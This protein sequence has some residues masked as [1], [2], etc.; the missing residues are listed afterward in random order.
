[1][2]SGTLRDLPFLDLLLMLSGK[3]GVLECFGLKGHGP[4]VIYVKRG[5]IRCIEGPRGFLDPDGAKRA[6][7]KLARAQNGGFEFSAHW[8]K[9][10][11]AKP[12]AWPVARVRQALETWL[13]REFLSQSAE[14]LF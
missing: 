13:T 6:L 11:C 4:Y 1:V 7:K 8:F 12:F 10:P 2:T 3:T 14:R 5:E 9:T